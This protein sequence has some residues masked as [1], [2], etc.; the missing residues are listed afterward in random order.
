MESGE[1]QDILHPRSEN[2]MLRQTNEELVSRLEEQQQTIRELQKSVAG[3]RLLTDNANDVL[4]RLDLEYRT[5]Y[6]SPACE[7]LTGFRADEIIGNHIAMSFDEEG[8]ETV[9]RLAIQ[10]HEAELRGELLGPLTFEARHR[11]K[12]GSWVWAESST[13]PER[14]ADGVITGYFGI[15]RE[16]TERKESELLILEAKVA[17]EQANKA[18]SE[19]L[20]L[21]SHEI[22]TPL[23]SLVGFSRMARSTTDPVKLD[24]Y[25]AILEESSRSLM[26][27]VNNILDMSKIEAERLECEAVPFNLGQLLV[28]L[29]DD[30]RSLAEQKLLSFRMAVSDDLP[31]WMMGDPLR[32]RQILA[33]LLANAVKFTER[34]GIICTI[35][36]SGQ[37]DPES[38]LVSFEVRDTG[39]GIPEQK[40]SLLYKPFQQ[41]DPSISRKYGGTGLGLA[42]VQSLVVMMG[43]SISLISR[44]GEGSCFTVELPLP[45]TERLPEL[46]PPRP[47]V[48]ASGMVLVV[49]D[50]R[51]N[52]LLFE[53]ILTE[54]GLRVILAE[55][56]LQALRLLVQQ[57]VDLIL[58]DIRMPGIDGIEVAR[59]I[60][61]REAEQGTAPVTIIAVT[62]DRDTATREACLGAGIN[63]VLAKPVIPEKLAKAIGVHCQGVISKAPELQPEMQPL[64]NQQAL[65]VLGS[66]Q[67]LI[68]KFRN[69]LSQDIE[70]ELKS[71]QS[72]LVLE[73]C[74]LLRRAAHTLKG[75]CG[76]LANP[77]PGE[78]AAW[79]YL[80]AASAPTEERDRV[81]GQLRTLSYSLLRQ[82]EQS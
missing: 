58:L 54:W 12:D 57:Q 72:A 39:I 44:E 6:I 47:V 16:I 50:N 55:D 69:I 4:W 62:A 76:Q 22:R 70:A 33:N 71:L 15:T 66:N 48:L 8:L 20:A 31:E 21:V 56:G 14:D 17:A 1:N 68:R 60:R 29:E 27:L 51:F 28:S 65:K 23:N 10:R 24:Q 63:E 19:F 79:L 67:D 11:Y 43:G 36:M 3:Y 61:R 73:D 18:K 30:Y 81:A 75:L 77:V 78:L 26:D 52:R 64:L 34:G 38:S 25:H 42:I 41:V 80:N 35:G 82:E 45:E 7:K 32:L 5:I 46:L 9:K 53:E 13:T 40:Q 49:E 74:Q 59:R 37:E 2:E